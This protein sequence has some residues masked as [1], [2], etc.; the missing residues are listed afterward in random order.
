[1]ADL[2]I[3]QT[4]PVQAARVSPDGRGGTPQREQ[5]PPR[6]QSERH[7]AD[8]LAVALAGDG[9]AAMEAHFEQDAEGNPLIRIVDVARGE[10]VAVVTPEELRALTEQTGL[11]PG[12]LLR[13]S[14]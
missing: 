1:M 3:Q 7:G 9:R 6:E 8:E 4:Q 12:L 13:T 2:R 14:K 5:A 10:T 11:P